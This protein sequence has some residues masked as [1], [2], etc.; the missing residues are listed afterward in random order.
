MGDYGSKQGVKHTMNIHTKKRV[1]QM[2]SE[3]D[4][5]FWGAICDPV[6]DTQS[7]RRCLLGVDPHDEGLNNAAR[8]E[9][10]WRGRVESSLRE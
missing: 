10:S 9:D 6:K 8:Y 7:G 4:V 5:E 3:R 1:V 2:G